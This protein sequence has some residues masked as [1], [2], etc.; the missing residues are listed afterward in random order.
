MNPTVNR[1]LQAIGHCFSFAYDVPSIIE[2][3]LSLD[4]RSRAA[5]CAL[6][7]RDAQFVFENPQPAPKSRLL[8]FERLSRLA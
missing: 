5:V 2:E 7:G 8:D 4:G 1:P 6:E 3:F